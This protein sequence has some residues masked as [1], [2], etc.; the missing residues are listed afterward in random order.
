MNGEL[1]L[2][3]IELKLCVS[4]VSPLRGMKDMRKATAAEG[5]GVTRV[6]GPDR[7]LQPPASMP[8]GLC[9][10]SSPVRELSMSARRARI[11]P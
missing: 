1:L 5:H 4:L 11:V 8:H 10:A 3:A 6:A 7:Q 2:L 9:E